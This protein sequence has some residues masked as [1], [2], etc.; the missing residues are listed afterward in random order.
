[1]SWIIFLI[2]VINVSLFSQVSDDK[3]SVFDGTGKA[4][5]LDAI[6]RRAGDM[7]VV[8]LG[9]FHDDS[10]GHAL[11]LE[12][13]KRV[14]ENYG[15]ERKVSLSLEMF[16]RDVQVVLD[17]YLNGLIPEKQ[18]LASSRPWGNYETD[19]RPLVEL[20]KGNKL[21]VVAANAPRRYV[22]MVSRLG[23]QSLEKLSPEAVNWLAPLPFPKSS[24]KYTEKFNALMGGHGS[25]NIMDSQTLWDATMANSIARELKSSDK[26]LVVHLNGAFHTESR[27]GT[28]EQLLNYSPKTRAMVVTVMYANDFKNFDKAKHTGIGDFVILTD[29]TQPRS[30]R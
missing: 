10:V 13:F 7:D 25:E 4:S 23:R 9:E 5:S 29:P 6:A 28:V 27:L 20:A 19:Y 1:M 16:E 22:N 18:F 24:A 11:Q 12:I 26:S 14:F 17:E 15:K 2:L 21:N 8:F 3:Y 30:K